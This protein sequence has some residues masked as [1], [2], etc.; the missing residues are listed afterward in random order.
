M[1]HVGPV[2]ARELVDQLESEILHPADPE[3]EGNERAAGGEDRTARV[4]GS[5]EPPD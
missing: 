1:I 3:V 4:P 5:I 2:R